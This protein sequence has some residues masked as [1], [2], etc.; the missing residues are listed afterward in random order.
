M[1]KLLGVMILVAVTVGVS[2]AEHQFAV[3]QSGDVVKVIYKNEDL[4][5]VNVV[6]KDED[7]VEVFKEDLISVGGFVRPYNL[8]NL[9][10]GDYTIH[11]KDASGELKANISHRKS[12]WLTHV[13]RLTC[14]DKKFMVIVPRQGH[15]D[16]TVQIFDA[17]G[18]L[19]FAEDVKTEDEYAKVFNLKKTGDDPVINLT[20]H[21][22]GEIK[23]FVAN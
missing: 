5:Q 2:N 12:S 4:C 17:E 21:V 3:L 15:S 22:T 19:L 16:F 6:I 23:H 18:V 9:E 13:G 8:S 1:K 10:K 7:G 14:P 11:L 20:N